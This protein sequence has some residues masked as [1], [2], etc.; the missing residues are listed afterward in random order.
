MSSFITKTK[1]AAASIPN[2]SAG[3][4]NEF[5][6]TDGVTKSKNESGTLEI[7]SGTAAV[8]AHVA[9]ADPH[10]QYLTSTEGSGLYDALGSA[11][12]VQ[13]NLTSHLN[14][15]SDPHPQYVKDDDE[16][17][18]TQNIVKVK[19][20]AG[21]NEFSSIADA[22]A[23][24]SGA[25]LINP[26]VIKVAAGL[27]TEPELTLPD[28]V[29]LE[30]EAIQSTLIQTATNTQHLF[31]LGTGCE[32]SF[33][34]LFGLGG[35]NKAAIKIDN[36]GDFAMTH[37]VSIY[38][39]DI[40]IEHNATTADSNLYV[41]YT[42]INGDYS[43]GIKSTSSGGFANRTQLENFYT[44]ESTAANAISISGTGT[45]LE[46]QIFSTKL[47]CESTQKGIVVSNGVVLRCNSVD[48]Q[49]AA[50]A[51]QIEN[52]G[53][54]GTI[55]TLST[56][57]KNNAIDYKLDHPNTTG[58]IFGGANLDNSQ[59][60]ATAN[61][62]V[63]LLDQQNEGIA[64]NGKIFYSKDSF[65]NLTDISQLITN[66]PTMGLI[67]GGELSVSSG[68]TISIAA[69]YGYQM[70]GVEP[71]DILHKR[72]W[73]T[74]TLLLSAN[75]NVFIYMND[76]GTFVSNAA[77]PDTEEN[78]LLGRAITNATD[79]IFIEKAPMLAHHYSN[80]I[81]K[82][83]RR[84]LGP[85]YSTGSLVSESGTRNLNVTA[86][87][88]YYSSNI[89]T[90][91]GGTAISFDAFYE[92]S[93]AGVYTRVAAQ[94][95][96]DNG[97]YDNGSGT[98]QAIPS[99]KH[100]KHLLLV[101]GGPSEK[102][103]LIYGTDVYTTLAE[104]QAAPLPVVPSYM[105][106]AF[107]RV[108]SIIVQHANANIQDIIDERPRIGFASSSSVGGVTDHGALSGLGDDDHTQYLLTNGSRAMS[109]SL[110]MGSNNIT[111]VGTIN[112][113]TIETHASRHL[114]NGADP[115]ATGTP[116][117]IGSANAVGVA[118]AFARQDHVHALPNVGTAGTFGSA[119]QV[120]VIT[121]DAKGRIT[122]AVSTAISIVSSAVSDFAQ[123][124]RDSVL[125]GI[126]FATST[127]V[128]ATD[129]VLQAIGK[130]Q[131]QISLNKN[132]RQ[133]TQLTNSSNATLTSVGDLSFTAVAG[134][135]YRFSVLLLYRSSAATTGIVTTI[136]L[137]GGAVG[138]LSAL[139]MA[140]IAAD[141]TAA[142]Y[143]GAITASADVVI[144]NAVPVANTDYIAKMEGVFICTTSGT[145]TP[146]F[147][148]ETNGQTV[149]V[150]IG[151]TNLV[152][153]F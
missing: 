15:T 114:P 132:L 78:L 108:A 74:Q 150:Q 142:V 113:V 8:A 57:L 100:V 82:A 126:S 55:N 16:R 46:L 68:L 77:F 136:T 21:L 134:K 141:G 69:G 96:V 48:S 148:S 50:V 138:T 31:I 109:G 87:E 32:I 137:G 26:Y 120:A 97:F 85:I 147:R 33:C 24:I 71:D 92:S 80:Q 1:I 20:N 12:T 35:A 30:G 103:I 81:D 145:V 11:A 149:T 37:K 59:I 122:S 79:I 123:G 119:S 124:V 117:D 101:L 52:I 143:H 2:A 62:S 84:A 67:S 34:S 14:D 40:G 116:V 38:D 27:Y 76:V 127:A 131:A 95:V 153:E 54:G 13:G 139:A 53:T 102:Y 47:F 42:D 151:S 29:S 25:S 70:N 61:I 45:A 128:V 133:L 39:F 17:L 44:F 125:T 110:N 73:T 60:N 10:S 7:Y 121:T 140:P 41:E 22:I 118:N 43:F 99:S 129:N 152:T 36:K 130:L 49:G 94:T 112:S 63:F 91:A 144:S 18:T 106:G 66:T 86:G 104:A 51:I 23:S 88:Y 9:L 65:S 90:P 4:V 111:S 64:L 115:L 98:L 107:S 3:K 6:D 58:S 75:S 93:T 105:D 56:A 89:F 72:E 135:T 5:V 83:F 19:L 28:F 146:Q